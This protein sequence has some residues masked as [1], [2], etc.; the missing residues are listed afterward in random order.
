M[1]FHFR[2]GPG[3]VAAEMPGKVS[4]TDKEIRSKRLIAFPEKKNL[5]FHKLNIG[6]ETRV[7]FEKTKVD[8]YITGFTTN[9]IKVEYP[10][11]AKTRR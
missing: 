3:T 5:E 2:K 8:G 6:Q 1:F 4:S 9:Y 10:L 11:A 7:L